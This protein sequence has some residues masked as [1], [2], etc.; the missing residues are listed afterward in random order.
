VN[1]SKLGKKLRREAATN[2]KKAALLGL[3]ALVAL[4]FWTPLVRGWIGKSDPS[5]ATTTVAQ[6]A[7]TPVAAATA[8]VATP[9]G[10]TSERKARADRPS[11]QQIVEWMRNDS[12][13][14]TAPSLITTRDPFQPA[15]IEAAA[16]KPIE[17]P[18]P[19]PPAIAPTAAGL[20]LTS[21]IIGP[22]RRVAQIN[23]KTYAVGQT[24]EVRK[25]KEAL[26]IAFRLI[27]VQPR[28][29]VL[30]TAGQRFELMIPEPNKSGK[31]QFLEVVGSGQ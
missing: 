21:T 1:L 8:S 16:T 6:S 19:K 26:G 30:E 24:I 31:I 25:E 23:G 22:Q 17:Q 10:Q 13:T 18:S 3:A 12:R 4:Y 14:M 15:T 11:W 29:A 7:A 2:P 28:R 5:M 20:V 9:A 27:E